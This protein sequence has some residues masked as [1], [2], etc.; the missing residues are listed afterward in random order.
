MCQ[1]EISLLDVQNR[2]S[3]LSEIGSLES[4]IRS[5]ESESWLLDV[6]NRDSL[7]SEIRSDNI[8]QSWLA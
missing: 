1:S 2:D 8:C 4:E 3:T 6:Q 7:E 5:E